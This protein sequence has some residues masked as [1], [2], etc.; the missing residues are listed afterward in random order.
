[1]S[2]L[3]KAVNEI[4]GKDIDNQ[5]EFRFCVN[6][7]FEGNLTMIK[8]HFLIFLFGFLVPFM[9][10]ILDEANITL[11]IGLNVMCLITE[12]FFISLE[13]LQLSKGY[14]I[15]LKDFWNYPQFFAF[16]LYLVYFVE[17]MRMPDKKMI[18]ETHLKLDHDDCFIV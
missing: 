1:M 7:L 5:M 18:P 4:Y 16:L 8:V 3:L 2:I 13:L 17:R 10:Q 9:V 14:R 11:V 12:L 6:S 15:Y